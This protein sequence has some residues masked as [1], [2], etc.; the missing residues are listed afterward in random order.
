MNVTHIILGWVWLYN[1]FVTRGANTYF[2][3]HNSKSIQLYLAKSSEAKP[4]SKSATIK[5]P[6]PQNNPSTLFQDLNL[7][8]EKIQES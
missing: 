7:K 4:K 6:N 1:L 5:W 3:K 2:L 8:K